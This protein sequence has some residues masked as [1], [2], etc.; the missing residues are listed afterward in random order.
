MSL[1]ALMALLGHRSPEMTI[2]YARLASPTLRTAYDQAIGK[3][4]RLLPIAPTSP[5]VV[6]DRVEWLNSE[7]L[8]TPVA[9][10]HCSRDT[11][12]R[13]RG[14]VDPVGRRARGRRRVA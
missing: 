1:H 11:A 3:M 10:G 13:A 6:P 9:H 12:P 5:A 14:P 7:M 4:R 2:R 8:E